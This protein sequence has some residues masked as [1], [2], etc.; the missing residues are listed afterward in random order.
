MRVSIKI[1]ACFYALLGAV[2][3]S[4]WV[5]AVLYIGTWNTSDL[6]VGLVPLGLAHGLVTLRHWAQTVGIVFAGLLAGVGV[7]SLILWVMHIMGY[8]KGGSGLIVDRPVAALIVIAL[9]IAGGAWQWWVLTR[10]QA[11]HLFSSK[12]A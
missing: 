1:I 9:M 11:D 7:I 5:Y 8:L 3:V 4:Q 12:P 2:S 10:P 6:L